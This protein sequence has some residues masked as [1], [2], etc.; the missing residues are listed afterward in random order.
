[1]N[2]TLKF[3]ELSSF[4]VSSGHTSKDENNNLILSPSKVYT[5][6]E[7]LRTHEVFKVD[8]IVVVFLPKIPP[9]LNK[10]ICCGCV[11]ESPR[12]GD[13]NTHQQHM[14]LWRNIENCHFLSFSFQPQISPILTICKVQIWGHFCAEMFP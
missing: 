6:R 14:V 10:I 12:R 4:E 3:S 9:A 7:R 5:L 11:L 1:M 13:S 8:K 2:S